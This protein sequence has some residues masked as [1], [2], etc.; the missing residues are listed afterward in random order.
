[1][2]SSFLNI[3]TP[4]LLKAIAVVLRAWAARNAAGELTASDRPA[5]PLLLALGGP[6]ELRYFFDRNSIR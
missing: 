2:S 4:D 6:G 1:M 5:R 3:T